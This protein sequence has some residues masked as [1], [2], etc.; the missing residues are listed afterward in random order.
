[1]TFPRRPRVRLFTALISSLLVAC[2]GDST[3]SPTAPGILAAKGGGAGAGPKVNAADPSFGDQGQQLNVRVLGSGYNPTAVA[4]WERNGAPDPSITVNSTTFVSSSEL[5]ANI[6]IAADADTVFYDV[7][8]EVLLAD[9]SRKK[10]VGIEKF[11]VRTGPHPPNSTAIATGAVISDGP[12]SVAGTEN[13]T[14]VFLSLGGNGQQ[15]YQFRSAFNFQ[16]TYDTY[17]DAVRL[18]QLPCKYDRADAAGTLDDD[19]RAQLFAKLVDPTIR[20]KFALN[21]TVD[22]D[23]LGSASVDHQWISH[24]N[25]SVET[26][27]TQGIGETSKAFPGVYPTVTEIAS[28]AYSFTGGVVYIWDRSGRVKDHLWI[29]CP[30]LDEA[31]MTW[32]PPAP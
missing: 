3:N 6:T 9:G 11:E 7:A 4:S 29:A 16:N 1:M 23:A 26:L 30:N 17:K 22:K 20:G 12:Q 14:T 25:E 8:V 2:A 28:H 5:V 19:R 13:D 15:G 24:W 31:V 27:F 10:G 32:T 21:F 18:G